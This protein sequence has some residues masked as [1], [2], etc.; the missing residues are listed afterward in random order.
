MAAGK[1]EFGGQLWPW[2]ETITVGEVRGGGI[3][4][5]P[6]DV[7]DFAAGFIHFDNGAVVH[8]DNTWAS[9][10]APQGAMRLSVMGSEGGASMWPFGIYR[11]QDGQIAAQ[12]CRLADQSPP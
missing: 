2:S 1:L 12:T 6:F 5:P 7:D 8:L 4:R 11:E 3:P 10:V 9:F